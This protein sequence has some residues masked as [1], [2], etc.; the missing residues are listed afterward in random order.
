MSDSTNSIL[1]WLQLLNRD[2]SDIFGCLLTI[3]TS[4]LLALHLNVPPP[5]LASNAKKAEFFLRRWWNTGIVRQLRRQ[6]LWAAMAV[7]ALE[8]LVSLAFDDWRAAS[9]GFSTFGKFGQGN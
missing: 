5:Y 6:L 3:V 7:I 2:T 8:L 4:T 1:E 9:L